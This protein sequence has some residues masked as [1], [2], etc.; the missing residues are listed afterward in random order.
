MMA[1]SKKDI[2]AVIQ[3]LRYMGQKYVDDDTVDHLKRILSK[4]TK[5]ELLK[6]LDVAPGWLRPKLQQIARGAGD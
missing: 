1:L 2:G 3:A 4:D 5:Q 6:N